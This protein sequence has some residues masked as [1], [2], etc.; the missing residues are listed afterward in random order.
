MQVIK[1]ETTYLKNFDEVEIYLT[2]NDGSH[3]KLTQTF[4]E[5]DK[6]VDALMLKR[7]GVRIVREYKEA[8]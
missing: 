8:E 6:M 5:F 2:A 3:V 4:E 1:L 7:D